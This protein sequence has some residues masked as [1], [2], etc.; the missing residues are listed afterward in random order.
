MV[1]VPFRLHGRSDAGVDC[2]GLAALAHDRAGFRGALP[3]AYGL[4]S[5][6]AGRA[7]LWLEQAGL[8]AVADEAAGDVLLVRPGPLQLHLMI[9]VE[10]G[11][12]HAHAGLRRVVEMPGPSPWAVIGAWRAVSK[13]HV[14]GEQ[15][16]FKPLPRGE[17]RVGSSVC[18]TRCNN[19]RLIWR[20]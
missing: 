4:R 16:Q 9:R 17:G 3:P 1:G 8:R 15:K 7:A 14:F 6:D 19:R 10:G 20:P 13:Q 5:G 12:V 2:V 18:G 11:F